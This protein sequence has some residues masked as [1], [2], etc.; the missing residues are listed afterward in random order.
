MLCMPKMRKY[1]LPKFQNITQNV[2]TNQFLM[3]P[4]KE[5]WQYIAVKNYQLY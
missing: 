3:V 4:N 1:I 5:R 2:K